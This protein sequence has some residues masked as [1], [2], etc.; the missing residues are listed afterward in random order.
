D[1][2]LLNYGP[3]VFYQNNGDGTFRNITAETGLQGPD[4]LN[5]FTK[6]SVGAVFWDYDR[7][8]AVDVMTGNFLAF[9][10]AYQSP[11]NP[12]LM[13]H[14]SEY[15][16]QASLLYRQSAPGRF[17]EVTA[18]HGLSYPDS[19]CMGLAVFD[20]DGDGAPDIL[21][22]NDHQANFLFRNDGNGAFR[23]SGIAS[24]IAVNDAG[25]PTGSMHPS[26]G[27][28]DGDGLIDVLVTDLE[29]GAL[30]RNLG[31]GLFEDITNRSGLSAV[32]NGIGA[33]GAALFDYDNDGDLDIFTAN[34]A[35]EVLTEQYPLLLENDGTGRFSDAADKAGPYFRQKR[36]GRGAATV[37]YDNDGDL[38]ILV[39]HVD[40]TATAALL[41]NDNA[42]GNHWLGLDLRSRRGTPA[43]PGA[44][45][46]VEA[47][48]TRQVRLHQPAN[49][50]L[51]YN[52]PR[53]HIG[54]GQER[55]VNRLTVNWPDG[56]TEVFENLPTDRYLELRQG[57]GAPIKQ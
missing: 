34:G 16:G 50:Y 27:D 45:I 47:G 26:L 40:L 30:Y 6:W 46:T 52:D 21:Q 2:Y 54:L 48:E 36:S 33:W 12:E 43:W 42:N 32:F 55:Q 37:D 39:S 8:G 22:A 11:A 51:S 1:L 44:R 13:P 7:D 38:D 25:A 57:S 41:R 3:N 19:K 17:E 15:R 18:A 28:I 20:S 23:E 53:V 14:P 31:N 5:N 10:P 24:G 35:A 56:Y 4:T 49:G 9:D 29:H